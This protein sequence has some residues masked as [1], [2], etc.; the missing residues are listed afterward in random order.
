MRCK[1]KKLDYEVK[2]RVMKPVPARRGLR[3]EVVV[4]EM[5]V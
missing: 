1:G 3:S 5:G 4:E 2:L